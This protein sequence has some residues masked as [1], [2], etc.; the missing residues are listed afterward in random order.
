[1]TN[2]SEKYSKTKKKKKRENWTKLKK[3]KTRKKLCDAFNKSP[4]FFCTGI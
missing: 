1:M 4:D 3:S 2:D